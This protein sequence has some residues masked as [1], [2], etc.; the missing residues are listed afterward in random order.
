MSVRFN[1]RLPDGLN[2][3]LE[4]EAGESKRTKS[5][6]VH[7]ALEAYLEPR[8]WNGVPVQTD[9]RMPENVVAVVGEDDAVVATIGCDKCHQTSEHLP[10][11]P[12]EGQEI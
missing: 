9:V 1:I 2:D 7:E 5:S 6:L 3:R 8:N 11:C 10:G 4:T 12:L